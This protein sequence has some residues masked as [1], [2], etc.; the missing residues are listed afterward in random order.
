MPGGETLT[1]TVESTHFVPSPSLFPAKIAGAQGNIIDDQCNY[2]AVK[3][4]RLIR[5]AQR[6]NV[7]VQQILE[8]NRSITNPNIIYPDQIIKIPDCLPK[9]P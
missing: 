8:A 3:D 9:T 6:F 4:D 2:K 5:I 1:P 7:T